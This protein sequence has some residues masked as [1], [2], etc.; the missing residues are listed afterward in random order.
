MFDKR[1]GQEGVTR[2]P[3]TPTESRVWQ[4]IG[5]AEISRSHDRVEV[6]HGD[7]TLAL[8]LGDA[9]I[10]AAALLQLTR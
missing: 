4:R 1:L 6:R 7:Q 2:A 5:D 3:R 8:A 9:R 10:L